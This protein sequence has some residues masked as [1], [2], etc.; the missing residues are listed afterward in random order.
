MLIFKFILNLLSK[1]ES[2]AFNGTGGCAKTFI[3]QSL[4]RDRYKTAKFGFGVSKLGPL[5]AVL[6]PLEDVNGKRMIN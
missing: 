1:P 4:S 5:A 3:N 2:F 6:C